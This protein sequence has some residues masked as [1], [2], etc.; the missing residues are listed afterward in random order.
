LSSLGTRK[1][2]ETVV[3]TADLTRDPTLA[4]QLEHG[5]ALPSEWYVDAT[6]FELEQR[7]IFGRHWQYAGHVGQVRNPGD[8]FTCEVGSVPLL[9]VRGKDGELRA[10]LNICPHRLHPVAAGAGNRSSLQCRY[11]AWT[12]KL[13]GKLA[14]A[15]RSE[16]EA[17]FDKREHCL[18]QAQVGT[19]GEL[20]FVNA[21]PQAPSLEDALGDF[22]NQIAGA[23][24]DLAARTYRGTRHFEVEANWKVI[25]ENSVE[26]YHCPTIHPGMS[27]ELDIG[28]ENYRIEHGPGWSVQFAP[29]KDAALPPER[30]GTDELVED[31]MAYLF[32]TTAIL[33]NVLS[34]EVFVFSWRPTSPS[35][36][37]TR[38]DCYSSRGSDDAVAEDDLF[39][40]I[41]ALYG[42]DLVVVREIQRNHRSGVAPRGT[43]LVDSEVAIQ[44]FQLAVHAAV[45]GP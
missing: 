25:I 26:C 39:E 27:A 2:K 37:V 34:S 14:G 32:P 3:A 21:D 9:V 45:A 42:Q 29:V 28:P 38:V 30:R 43:L 24:V 23:G 12:F 40:A 6:I 22:P 36:C 16:R 19:L 10:F 41:S 5:R 33:G 11:H 20:V 31:V 17:A 15:P 35:T 44:Q 13:D 8:F 4:E 7:R 18:T 1:S